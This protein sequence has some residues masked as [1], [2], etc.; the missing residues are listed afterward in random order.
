MFAAMGVITVLVAGMAYYWM[1]ADGGDG[2]S[3]KIANR[4]VSASHV[5]L[6]QDDV[7]RIAYHVTWT[8]GRRSWITPDEY[9][10]AIYDERS[11]RPWHFAFLNITSPVG[12]AWVALGLLGQVLFTGRM[13]LQWLVSEKQ[14]QSVVPTAFWWMSLA[15]ASMLIT[16]FIWRKDAVGVLGQATGWAIYARNL[17]LIHR[18]QPPVDGSS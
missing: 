1:V 12:I 3:I 5:L 11:S 13:I 15:G 7:G 2:S 18:H 14:K 17:W 10:Q 9:A 16:Y 8:D 6:T 4:P